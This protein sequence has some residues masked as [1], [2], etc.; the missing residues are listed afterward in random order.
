[1]KTCPSAILSTTNPIWPDPGSNPGR[2]GGK[3]ATNRL[4]YG[5]AIGVI[6]F[7][8]GSNLHSSQMGDGKRQ[9]FLEAF[10]KL[11]QRVLWKWETDSLPGQPKNVMLGKWL[12]QSDILGNSPYNSLCFLYVLQIHAV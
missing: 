3:P 1:V 4:S 10:S 9:A 8:M 11:K 2:R 12:P 5:P 6:Y 7:S